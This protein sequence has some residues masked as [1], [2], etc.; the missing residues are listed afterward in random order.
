MYYF[1]GTWSVDELVSFESEE[2]RTLNINAF[3]MATQHFAVYLGTLPALGA[4]L[5]NQVIM[6]KCDNETSVVLKE[7]YRAHNEHM[8]SLLE[9][10]DHTTAP[11]PSTTSP[12]K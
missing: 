9:D 3:E 11:P 10:Y 2:P 8:A 4:P 6:P 12:S 5:A 1:F 7:S